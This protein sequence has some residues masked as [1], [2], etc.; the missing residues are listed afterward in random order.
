TSNT[1]NLNPVNPAQ[2]SHSESMIKPG[3]NTSALKLE[4]NHK[5]DILYPSL[6]T[7][8]QITSTKDSKELL[9]CLVENSADYKEE[10]D[11]SFHA[12]APQTKLTQGDVILKNLEVIPTAKD[13][14]SL[15]QLV[16]KLVEKIWVSLPST[17]EKEVRLFLNDG[18]LKGGEISIKHNTEGYSV[19]IRQEHALS[20]INPQSRQELVERL[21]KLVTDIPIR[22]SISEQ[23]NQQGD[24]QRSKQQRNIYDEW[25]P[26]ED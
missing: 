26:E 10:Q 1:V 2:H 13:P 25:N 8:K 9:Q 21:Q 16:N 5:Q 24:Q 22:V 14:H 7:P 3:T 19:T 6:N 18:Q 11:S 15:T 20:H 12:S 17:N 4:E 23:M